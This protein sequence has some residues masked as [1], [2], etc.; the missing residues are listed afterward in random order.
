[1]STTPSARAASLWR[2]RSFHASGLPPSD[3]SCAAAPSDMPDSDAP[4]LCHADDLAPPG[5]CAASAGPAGASARCDA[6]TAPA[7]RLSARDAEERRPLPP[8]CRVSRATRPIPDALTGV[9]GAE[10]ENGVSEALT[11]PWP[12]SLH[13]IAG[14][15]GARA[16]RRASARSAAADRASDGSVGGWTVGSMNSLAYCVSCRR[17]CEQERRGRAPGD[18]GTAMW[19]RQR[20]QE[21]SERTMLCQ[22][23]SQMKAER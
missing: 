23:W 1:M 10:S 5:S 4:R 14:A 20:C 17:E 11:S 8:P 6:S 18:T 7:T 2:S 16:P 19:R 13:G 15:G 9:S 3:A 22:Y 12:A 21:E